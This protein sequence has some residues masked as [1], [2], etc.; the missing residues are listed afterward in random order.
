MGAA[1]TGYEERPRGVKGLEL[2][3]SLVLCREL[4]RALCAVNPRWFPVEGEEAV[5]VG[6][7]C[8]LRADDAAAPHYRGPFVVYLMRGAE[9]WRLCC[10]AL[11]RRDGYNKGRSV[12]FTGPADRGFVP[13]VA[14]DLGTTIGV[15]TGAALAFQREGSD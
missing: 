15:A 9:M 12:P 14:G 1:D 2:Y 7:F 11:G 8:D 5:V 3:R 10:Q 6:A 13:W 4:E